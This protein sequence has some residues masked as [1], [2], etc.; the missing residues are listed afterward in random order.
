MQEGGRGRNTS[1]GDQIF[2]FFPL[3]PFWHSRLFCHPLNIPYKEK[4]KREDLRDEHPLAAY[5]SSNKTHK[6]IKIKIERQESR[7]EIQKT[8]PKKEKKNKKRLSH[9][10][11]NPH[12]SLPLPENSVDLGEG[13]K[14]K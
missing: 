13:M 11:R 10:R 5:F 8:E 9:Q 14:K 3:P 6:K 2:P 1:D 4:Q 7:N 12:Y